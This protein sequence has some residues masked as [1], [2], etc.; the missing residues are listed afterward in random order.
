[1]PVNET[2]LRRPRDHPEHG[3][4][5]SIVV[6]CGSHFLRP[7]WLFIAEQV[8]CPKRCDVFHIGSATSEV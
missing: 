3:A 2:P 7:A 1:M 5:H 8:S 6:C 4:F